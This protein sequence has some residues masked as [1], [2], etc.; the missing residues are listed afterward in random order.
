MATRIRY[1]CNLFISLQQRNF[2]NLFDC[3]DICQWI[4]H[5]R[6]ENQFQ[7]I[8]NRSKHISH[9][10]P[11]N[12]PLR[13]QTEEAAENGEISLTGFLSKQ[14]IVVKVQGAGYSV[15]VCEHK[16][17]VIRRITDF[18]RRAK[19]CFYLMNINQVPRCTCDHMTYIA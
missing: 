3:M 9:F 14:S 6:W 19:Q 15:C 16:Y 1:T 18:M 10:S 5:H 7:C 11:R 4:C 12:V 8:R 13:D 2:I 17:Q